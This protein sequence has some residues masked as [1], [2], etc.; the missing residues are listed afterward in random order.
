MTALARWFLSKVIRDT[1]DNKVSR[2]ENDSG[3]SSH[4]SID[5]YFDLQEQYFQQRHQLDK[6]KLEQAY[7][8]AIH[9]S[10]ELRQKAHQNLG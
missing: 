9:E 5:A 6:L 10:R 7:H 3:F 1:S 4:E 2:S 8:T